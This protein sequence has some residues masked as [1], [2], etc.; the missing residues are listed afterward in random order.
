MLSS[1]GRSLPSSHLTCVSMLVPRSSV[2]SK[3][4]AWCA[5]VRFPEPLGSPFCRVR[6]GSSP[7]MAVISL[8]L[9]VSELRQKATSTSN[10][11]SLLATVQ[12]SVG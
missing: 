8:A 10:L 7:I 5:K 3:N 6:V 12:A 2:G 4:H 1:L 11:V 9:T